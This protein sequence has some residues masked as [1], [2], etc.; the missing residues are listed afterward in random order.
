[1]LNNKNFNYAG[2]W[3]VGNLDKILF[4]EFKS[5]DQQYLSLWI[6][7]KNINS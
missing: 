4:K 7:N 3:A 1:M 6:Q 2:K 5:G